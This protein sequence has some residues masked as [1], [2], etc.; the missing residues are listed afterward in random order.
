MSPE[1]ILDVTEEEYLSAGSKFAEVGEHLSEMGTPEWE[2]PGQSIR[3]PFTIIEE[4]ADKGKENKLVAGVSKKAIWKLKEIL[5][6]IG[7]PCVMKDGK[8]T[9]NSVAVQGKK[10][11]SV[12]EEQKDTRTPEEGGT[13]ATYSKPVG[14]I[15]VDATTEGLL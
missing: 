8:P 13:G 15:P 2:S 4:G 9:F 1:F 10:F 14:A 11:K 3:F 12:W 5:D 7:V 6:A